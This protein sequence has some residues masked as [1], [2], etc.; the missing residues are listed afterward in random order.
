MSSSSKAAEATARPPLEK[1]GFEALVPWLT[2]A[3]GADKLAIVDATLLAGGAVQQNWRLDVEVTGGPRSGR[4][5]WVLRT[6]AAASLD[7]SLDRMSEF[8][9]IEAA[10]HAGVRVAEPIAATADEGLIGRPFAIQALVSGNAQGRRIVRDPDLPAFGDALATE[11]GRELALI[12]TITP[13]QD[14]LPFLPVP[15]MNP[16]RREVAEMRRGLD[17]ASER[18]PALE[19]ILSW[20]DANAPEPSGLTLVHGDFRTGNY[21]VDKGRLTAV[22]DWEFCH[23]GD[24]RED[25]G[26]FIARCWR[27]GNDDKVA[28]G[29][30]RL[31]SLLE[32]YNAHAG[33]SI[34]APELAYFEVLAAAR[35][36]TISLLQGDR[37]IQGGERSLELALTG[38]MPPEMEWDALDIIDRLAARG[39]VT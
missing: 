14:V 33:V 19:Y 1:A 17:G 31:A 20:L 27:F 13:R 16:S 18:R 35:W 26:W 2:T 21:M 11:I 6:D 37:F 32:G 3:V 22:L 23:W 8:R 4:Q 7:V 10:H 9:C 36:A 15:V 24:P 39:R 30:A 25:L 38:L 34:A 12:H 28:G 5:S 29:I